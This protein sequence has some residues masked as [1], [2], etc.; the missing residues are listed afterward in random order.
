L[1]APSSLFRLFRPAEDGEMSVFCCA[2]ASAGGALLLFAW[3]G[4]GA[5]RP[6]LL[7]HERGLVVADNALVLDED[8]VQGMSRPSAVFGNK[9]LLLGGENGFVCLTVELFALDL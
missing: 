6:T 9:Q 1:L 3:A 5:P 4:G 7:L 2:H 8:L